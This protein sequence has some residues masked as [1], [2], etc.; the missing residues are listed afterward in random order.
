MKIVIEIKDWEDP[1][2]ALEHIA[3]LLRD[4]Y[5]SGIDPT[6]KIEANG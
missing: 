3:D 4:E 2:E 1:V 6:W 5:T